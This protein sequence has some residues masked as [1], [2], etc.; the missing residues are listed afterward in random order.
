MKYILVT[1]LA[2]SLV[3]CGSDGKS[4]SQIDRGQEVANRLV[5]IPK[6][7]EPAEEQKYRILRAAG[8]TGL[9]IELATD[10]VVLE[11]PREAGAVMDFILRMEIAINSI[12]E[13]GGGWWF[14]SDLSD[15]KRVILYSVAE[16]L[17]DE[18]A[19][20]MASG[21]DLDAVISVIGKQD[22]VFAMLQD[23]QR[24]VDSVSSGTQTYEQAL[25]VVR[26]RLE[27]NKTRLEPHLPK[28]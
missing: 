1:L 4:L 23:I 8:L 10:R 21:F 18:L 9:A 26:S 16:K 5:K 6:D 28:I 15:A 24:I 17:R 2:L 13:P 12:S 25:L 19:A 22:K 7:L 3:G 11:S 20:I 14:S 27:Y